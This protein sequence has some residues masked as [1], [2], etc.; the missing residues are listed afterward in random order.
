MII[1]DVHIL[2]GT[3]RPCIQQPSVQWPKKLFADRRKWKQ[4]SIKIKIKMFQEIQH[5]N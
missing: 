1:E 3:R 4:E 2:F 5:L